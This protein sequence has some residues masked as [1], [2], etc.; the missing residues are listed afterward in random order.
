MIPEDAAAHVRAG[1]DGLAKPRGSLGRLED[2][3]VALARA[4]ASEHPRSTPRRLVV[5]AADHGC[6][7]SGVSAWPSEITGAMI[8]LML[9]GGA[10]CNAL[11]RAT[12]T[13]LRLVDAGSLADAPRDPSAFYRDGREGRGSADLAHGAALSV[14]EW[15]AAWRVGVEEADRA[16]AQGYAVVA[17]G[18][19]GIGN[20][21]PA[22]CLTALLADVPPEVAAGPGAGADADTLARKRAVVA[23][24]TGRE[25]QHLAADPKR[26]IAA[27]AGR[28]IA[29][30]AGF[31]ARAADL[32]LGVVLDGYVTTAAALAAER[33]APGSTA[34]VIAGHRSAEPA[35]AA[36]LAHLGLV[37]LLELDMRLGEGTGA[38]AAMPLLDMAVAILGVTPLAALA[39]A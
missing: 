28:E 29:A 27:L 39:P 6:V 36:A 3:A 37:P 22:A 16:L 32:P 2:L 17:V 38:L 19:M 23:A 1:I 7:A 24:A 26:A 21:T 18:E 11:A 14:A 30:M 34:R 20:T 31:L 8:G 5:F 25:R 35:H 4:Q 33:L 9:A 15:D 13:D 10:S 12:G